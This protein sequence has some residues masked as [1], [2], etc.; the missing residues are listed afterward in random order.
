[1]GFYDLLF[2]YR[3][4]AALAYLSNDQFNPENSSYFYENWV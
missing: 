4:K 2:E 3:V 1:M